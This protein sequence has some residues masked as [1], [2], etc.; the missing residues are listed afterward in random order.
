MLGKGLNNSQIGDKSLGGL[1]RL[2]Y[3]AVTGQSLANVRIQG[4]SGLL[5]TVLIA[6]APQLILSFLY[7][8][9]NSLFT[10]M[11]LGKEWSDYA[12]QRKPLRVTSPIGEQRSTY[13]LQLPYSYGIPLLVLSGVLHWLVS[14]SIFLARVTAIGRDGQEDPAYSVSTCGY[15]CIAIVTAIFLGSIALIFGNLNGFRRYR[16]GMPLVGSCSAAISAACHRPEN[17]VDA[18]VLPVKWGVPE[19]K[20]TIGHCCFTSLEV[21]PPV[22]G[23]TYKGLSLGSAKRKSS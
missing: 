6:N 1:W 4:S 19:G 11:L 18:S 10:C 20:G 9:Y 2:G 17:D 22:E 23:Q 21:T 14:Q 13:R 16:D 8:T 12:Y 3:G 5:V 15:S 7:L